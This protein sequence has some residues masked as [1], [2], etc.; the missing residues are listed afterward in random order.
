MTNQDRPR[1]A[2]R[3][4]AT[5]DARGTSVRRA[6]PPVSLTRRAFFGGVGSSAIAAGG[7]L[8]LLG[9]AA[10]RRA[11]AQESEQTAGVGG[12]RAEFDAAAPRHEHA[13]QIR[14]RAAER[15]YDL[16]LPSVFPT[17]DEEL[18][19]NKLGNFSKGLPHD[20]LG[21]VNPFAYEALAQAVA[22]GDPAAFE[23]IPMGGVA[24]LRNPQAGLGFDLIGPDSHQLTMPRTPPIASAETAAEMGELYWQALARD[25]LF[26]A[27]DS[28]P[29]T[30]VAAEDLST[31]SD[32]RGPKVQG[33]RVD[34]R[35]LFRADIPGLVM[36]PFVSQ[37][38]L[39]DLP[40]GT[41]ITTQQ[42]RTA[43]PVDHLLTYD[44]WLA[45]Q[46]GDF[47]VAA[48]I[49]S[50]DPTPRYIRNGRDLAEAMHW[51]WPGQAAHHACLIA[52]GSGSVSPLA[53]IFT[54]RTGVALDPSNPYL[55]SQTQYGFGTFYLPHLAY[56]ISVATNSA[57]KA[58]WYQKWNVHRRLRPEEFGGRVHHV[59]AGTATYPV[60]VDLLERSA[61]LGEVMRRFGTPLL[62]QAF[63]EGAP[64]HPAYPS[65]HATWAGATITMLKAFLD[66]TATIANPVIAAADGLALVPYT[67]PDVDQLTTGG[68]LNKLAWNIAVGRLFAGIHWRTDAIEGLRLGETVALGILRDLRDTYNE[69]FEG[70]T[71]TTFDGEEMCV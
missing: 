65:G 26:T 71:L 59:V 38:L 9:P 7:A 58:A 49:P 67:G 11:L 2:A 16:P 35:T 52:F 17:S 34:P 13:Y 44:E 4:S 15:L 62:P 50:Y 55:H 37:F 36:G 19:P 42:I 54:D 63:P 45:V 14:M 24:K 12:M 32:F 25:V 66:E 33:R 70:Y 46:N 31:F 29:T 53:G 21:E 41:S 18:Y 51:D 27:Y 40:T 28:H 22:T 47:P 64:T 43:L 48:L 60:H 1:Q 69:D 10:T 30:V 5:T 8:D 57:L 3:R 68:E 56:L 39:K 61:V 6:A 23:A 20:E